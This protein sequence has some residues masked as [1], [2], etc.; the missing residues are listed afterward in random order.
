MLSDNDIECKL[1]QQMEVSFTVSG[2]MFVGILEMSWNR[3][4]PESD[5]IPYNMKPLSSGSHIS[6]EIECLSIGN[7]DERNSWINGPVINVTREALLFS[8]S[9]LTDWDWSAY[10][11]QSDYFEISFKEHSLTDLQPE[12]IETLLLE[13]FQNNPDSLIM[14][15]EFHDKPEEC[16]RGI[17]NK[18]LHQFIE[19]ILEQN[20]LHEPD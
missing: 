16:V 15:L 17:K 12:K 18:R 6:A 4:N 7:G 2:Y 9:E 20:V 11:C 8:E 3:L 13:Y 19:Q 1:S 10:T 14:L 5:P